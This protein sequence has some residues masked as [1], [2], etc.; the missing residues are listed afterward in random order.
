MKKAT[1][2]ILSM[3]L[4]AALTGCGA[5]V[6]DM[7]PEKISQEV[8]TPEEVTSEAVEST[9]T[10]ETTKDTETT[11][12]AETHE[13]AEQDKADS[14][15][16]PTFDDPYDAFLAGEGTLSFK[17]YKENIPE[18]TYL[19]Y[20]DRLI[21]CFPEDKEF[22]IK[23]FRDLI[24]DTLHSDDYQAVSPIDSSFEID[25]MSYAFLDCGADGNK[26]LAIRVKGPFVDPDSYI[27]FIVK[28]IDGSLQTIYAFAEWSRSETDLNEYGVLSGFG[29]GGATVH[30]WDKSFISADG[31]YN[32]G[33]SYEEQSELE[34][35]SRYHEHD[36]Y[37]YSSLEGKICVYT[38]RIVP[39]SEE[40]SDDEYY[41]YAV[42]DSNYDE[43]DIPNLYTDS[44]Y[45][46]LMDS[47]K[48][49][50]FISMDD[51]D[52]IASDK[53]KE[54]GITDKIDHGKPLEYMK[55]DF[56]KEYVHDKSADR[57][58][59][60]STIQEEL[61]L[62]EERSEEYETAEIFNLPQQQANYESFYWYQMW[63]DELNDLWSR[64]T[65]K[66]DEDRKQTLL[67]EQR[68]WIK[69]KEAYVTKAG[70]EFEGGTMQ[71]FL[72]NCAGKEYSR[73][74]CYELAEILADLAG[75]D[76]VI[77]DAVAESYADVDIP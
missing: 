52:K 76:F 27:T 7:G 14:T 40:T 51:M 32:F 63:D 60:T 10:A 56:D 13:A 3:A 69:R 17:Y 20:E 11:E 65:D 68:A 19:S 75:E 72:E 59:T 18:D 55:I 43:M 33:Y 26:E 16:I 70:A 77:P 1:I 45:Q 53:I 50:S 29:S 30:G 23:E 71:P 48:D 12:D 41:S 5:P 54:I 9:E 21:V 46:K 36:E 34:D 58:R 2:F 62:I 61:T 31:K 64:I 22:T 49:I 25:N 35:F 57:Y 42:Y 15:P 38:L 28:E 39:Y 73:K 4:I 24:T 37:Y 8:I 47:H 6:A 66:I 44:P 67:D 74:R